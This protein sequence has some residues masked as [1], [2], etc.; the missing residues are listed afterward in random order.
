M[1]QQQQGWTAS[2]VR[3]T[4]VKFFEGKEHVNWPS[5]PVVPVNDPTLLFA[6]AGTGTGAITDF[7]YFFFVTC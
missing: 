4:F 6:N 7:T 3:E 1:E 2:R 5:S